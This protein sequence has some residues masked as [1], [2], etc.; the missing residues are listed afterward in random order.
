MVEI[1][2]KKLEESR[3][4]AR[5]D[6]QARV[7]GAIIRI[8]KNA[9]KKNMPFEEIAEITELTLAEIEALAQEID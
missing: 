8:A 9:L 3:E 4:K 2:S 6:N 5:R 1:V 7:D